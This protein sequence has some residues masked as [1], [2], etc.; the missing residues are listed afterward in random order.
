MFSYLLFILPELHKRYSFNLHK[1]AAK[2]FLSQSRIYNQETFLSTQNASYFCPYLSIVNVIN[3]ISFEI[4]R[5]RTKCSKKTKTKNNNK[6]IQLGRV[7]FTDMDAAK[8]V[9]IYL[10]CPQCGFIFPTSSPASTPQTT[11]LNCW[12]A[13]ND[14]LVDHCVL[15][16]IHLFLFLFGLSF[17]LSFHRKF[18]CSHSDNCRKG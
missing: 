12:S 3:I 16:H 11:D 4:I 8:K 7:G 2:P 9:C 6:W 17:L 13:C 15:K 10:K 1:S 5:K 18:Q 14:H